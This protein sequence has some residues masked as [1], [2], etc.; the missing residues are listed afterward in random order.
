MPRRTTVTFK[1][2]KE[3]LL[4]L[5]CCGLFFLKDIQNICVGGVF[6]KLNVHLKHFRK[7]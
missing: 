7:C 1:V 2:K 6:L 5:A 3:R 4:H